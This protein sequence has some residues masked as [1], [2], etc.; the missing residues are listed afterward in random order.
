MKAAFIKETGEPDV[1]QYDNLP[2]PSPSRGQLLIEV[3]AVSVN[4]IDTYIRSGK[5]PME[6][7]D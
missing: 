5:I 3:E 2:D 6:N 1:I 4:P 7:R